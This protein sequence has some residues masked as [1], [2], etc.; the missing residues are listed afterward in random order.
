MITMD[1]S[2]LDNGVKLISLNGALDMA[3]HTAI[4]DRF[5]FNATT[6]KGGVIVDMSGV[7]FIASIGIR[8]LLASAKSLDKRG[9]KMGL[10][11]PQSN[12]MMVLANTGIDQMIPIYANLDTACV[13]LST[14]Q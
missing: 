11:N 5:T 2:E 3:G 4:E 8:L 7:D 13:E 10:Y 14:Y 1:V 6:R 9:G 12:V